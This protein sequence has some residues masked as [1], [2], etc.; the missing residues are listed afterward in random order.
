MITQKSVANDLLP[1]VAIPLALCVMLEA[2]TMD[3]I[4]V[5][6]A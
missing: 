5:K 6:K 2:F 3:E 4:P 1:A